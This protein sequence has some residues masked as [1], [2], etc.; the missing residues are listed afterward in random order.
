[1]RRASWPPG[2]TSSTRPSF[3]AALSLIGCKV[4]E[5]GAQREQSN[6]VNSSPSTPDMMVIHP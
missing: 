1:L 6:F 5:S 3:L 2:T 4:Q